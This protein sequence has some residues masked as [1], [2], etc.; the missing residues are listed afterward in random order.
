MYEFK[1][2]DL[3]EGIHEGEILKWHV[4]PG[5][6][7]KEDEPLVDVETDK[8]AVTI[9]APAGGVVTTVNGKVGDT[10]HVG[11]VI[12]VIDDGSGETATKSAQA[13]AAEPKASAAEPKASAAE[14]KASAAEPKA[15]AAE[16]PKAAPGE[17]KGP[18]PAA[19]A[20]RRIAREL[21][22]RL[23]D[24]PPTGP[25]GRVTTE[26]VQRFA[27]GGGAAPQESAAAETTAP[28]PAGENI[29][30]AGIPLLDV[31]PL[32]DFEEWGEVEKVPLR[33]IRRKIA[34]KMVSSSILVPHVLHIDDADVTEIEAFRREQRARLG[35]RPGGRVT[36][37]AFLMKAVAA[38]LKKHPELNASLDAVRQELIYKKFYNI[39]F[40]SDTGKGLVVP[41]VHEVDRKSVLEVSAA[42]GD[43][44]AR[45]R[46]DAL[47]VA[48]LRGGTF[49]ITNIGPIG[50]KY[51]SPIINYPE[52]AILAMGRTEQR[53]VVRD[54]EIVVRTILPLSL[55]FDHRVADGANAARFTNEIIR[56]LGDPG[57]LLMEV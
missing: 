7:I 36:L 9:P 15:S 14:P 44:G 11:D 37:M 48:D 31:G 46:D 19:P 23:E 33:S 51:V 13:S 41:V 22:V 21:G 20:T 55:A 45:A 56:L 30:A 47:E 16:K 32:E 49:T 39:G 12:V 40:A 53:P 4:E 8:A 54:G 2:P 52:V 5:G 42:I 27:E 3:G 25:G 35:D 57:A 1:L 38:T 18:V 43:L 28:A 6:E 50:G 17:R 29:V 34:R 24:V 26:D 10:V